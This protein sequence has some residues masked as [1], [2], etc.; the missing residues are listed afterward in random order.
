MKLEK[1]WYAWYTL[2]M[3]VD[4]EIQ[5]MFLLNKELEIHWATHFIGLSRVFY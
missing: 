4:D 5:F 3:Y 2:Y 1:F